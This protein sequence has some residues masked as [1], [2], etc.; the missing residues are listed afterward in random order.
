MALRMAERPLKLSLLENCWT[1][2][3]HTFQGLVC[4]VHRLNKKISIRASFADS[5]TG[6]NGSS[7]PRLKDIV[8]YHQPQAAPRHWNTRIGWNVC[9]FFMKPHSINY[10]VFRHLTW[11]NFHHKSAT[12]IS[13]PWICLYH[14]P[15]ICLLG[16]LE[17]VK[18]ISPNC[19]FSWW[20]IY[21]WY[22]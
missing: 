22:F 11:A 9:E 10:R 19:V 2:K 12:N 3:I 5:G 7:W 14:P 21:P 20:F 1:R 8:E 16:C 13:H 6:N 17:I 18:N 4:F 15:W